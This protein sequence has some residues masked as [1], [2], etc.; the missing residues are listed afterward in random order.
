MPD[1]PKF[2]KDTE[3]F[4][5]TSE[6][7]ALEKKDAL[8]RFYAN[9]PKNRT[10]NITIEKSNKSWVVTRHFEYLSDIPDQYKI[11]TMSLSH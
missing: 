1:Q 6:K 9:T 3:T 7:A 4:T 8:T 10:L 11:S 2:V 5:V